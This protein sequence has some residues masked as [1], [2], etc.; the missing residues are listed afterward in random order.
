MIFNCK[1]GSLPHCDCVQSITVEKVDAFLE[2]RLFKNNCSTM[3]RMLV[4]VLKYETRAN[5]RNK[6][7]AVATLRLY[8][9]LGCPDVQTGCMILEIVLHI[10]LCIESS[11]GFMFL[12]YRIPCKTDQIEI[13]CCF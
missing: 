5:L 9:G 11:R 2:L 6:F 8:N 10:D 13:P 1:S 3:L 7:L 4:M 12:L